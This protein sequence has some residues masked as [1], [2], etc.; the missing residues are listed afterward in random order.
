MSKRIVLLLAGL[1]LATLPAFAVQPL[2]SVASAPAAIPV[3]E[4][5]VLY[6]QTDN[7]G[8]NSITSQNFEAASDAFDNAAADDFEVPAGLAWTVNEV[9]V[10][11][12]YFNGPGPA[13]S[14]DVNFYADSGG[15]PGAVECTAAGVVPTDAAGSFNIALAAP[16]VLSEG[17]HWVSVIANMDF[18]P[19]GQWG[20]TERTVQSFSP[21]AW[22]NPGGG[23]GTPCTT[24]GARAG[25]CLVGTDPDLGFTL[26]GTESAVASL[27]EV[28]TLG[29]WGL[30][31]LAILLAAGSLRLLRRRKTA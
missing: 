19:G 31:A 6:D 30:T 16:C 22:Q 20:W 10:P 23:F 29:G 4:G 7:L 2:R 17:A 12:V 21:S 9:F 15:L 18:A 26:F 5:A 24:W 1:A 27:I 3:H 13:A 25:L 28:P 11:G 14:V 8:A